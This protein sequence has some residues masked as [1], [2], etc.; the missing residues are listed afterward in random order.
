MHPHRRGRR[1]PPRLRPPHPHR[2]PRLPSRTR[3][4]PCSRRSA[5]APR[6]GR[7]CS[8][9]MWRS[10]ARWLRWGPLPPQRSNA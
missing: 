6:S 2:R 5:P 3:R 10:G 1:R 8:P 4:S 7:M 9:S